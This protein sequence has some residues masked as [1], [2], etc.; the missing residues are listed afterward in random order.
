MYVRKAEDEK[1][2]KTDF[3][4]KAVE[5]RASLSD[6]ERLQVAEI[7]IAMVTCCFSYVSNNN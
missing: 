2:G 3:E 6:V 5:S 7:V 1:E 4:A